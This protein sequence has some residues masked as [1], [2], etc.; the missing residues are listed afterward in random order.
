M[1][2][3]PTPF[4]LMI[5]ELYPEFGAPAA[6]GFL[7]HQRDRQWQNHRFSLLFEGKP[8]ATAAAAHPLRSTSGWRGVCC[9]AL[10][11]AAYTALPCNRSNNVRLVSYDC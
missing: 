8:A 4:H 9:Y 7:Y 2:S 10:E 11:Q 1:L 5:P 3:H 6:P